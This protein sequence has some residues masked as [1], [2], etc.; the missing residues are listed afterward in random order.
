MNQ[1]AHSGA[2]PIEIENGHHAHRMA[3]VRIGR[4]AWVGSR[5]E[6]PHSNTKVSSLKRPRAC[7][8][9]KNLI[10]LFQQNESGLRPNLLRLEFGST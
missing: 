9:L 8:R 4:G 3:R 10:P 5:R 1:A 6:W 7:V 2:A